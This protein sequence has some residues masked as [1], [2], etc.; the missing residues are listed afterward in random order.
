VVVVGSVANF[1]G[2]NI[3]TSKGIDRRLI[4]TATDKEKLQK[5]RISCNCG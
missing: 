4:Y 5:E 1:A 2:N 3:D